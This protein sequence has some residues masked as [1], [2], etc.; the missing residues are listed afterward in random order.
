MADAEPKPLLTDRGTWDHI[1]PMSDVAAIIL[2]AGRGTRF[3]QEPK[4]L[5]CMAGRPL[6]QHVADAALRSLADPVFVVTGHQ[7]AM[8][9]GV[10]A[11]L[12]VHIVRNAAFIDGLSTSLKAGFAALPPEAR[13]AVVLLGDMP[14]IKTSLI[15]T[16]VRE[17]QRA[18]EPMALVPT[19]DGR[20][21][22]P[23]VLS[24][25][26][27]GEIEQLSGDSGAGPI[28]RGRSDVLEYPVDDSAILQDVDT[29]TDFGRVS[30]ESQKS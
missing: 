18:G 22:N 20:R 14:L 3:G 27:A 16:L 23:V 21:G 4:L 9:E 11:G 15:D 6:V 25:D 19:M 28:L 26:L 2:A 12:P 13:A 7:A 5:A 10:L 17:W 24:R 29:P 1:E 30:R 8:V